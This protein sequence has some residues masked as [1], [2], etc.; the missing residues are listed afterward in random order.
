MKLIKIVCHRL[1]T[2]CGKSMIQKCSQN[3]SKFH[4]KD[5]RRLHVLYFSV[6]KAIQVFFIFDFWALNE[7]LFNCLCIG[8]I[9]CDVRFF[10]QENE[11]KQWPT[12]WGWIKLAPKYD[13]I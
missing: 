1:V 12:S 5:K 11:M 9:E 13:I 6:A 10:V 3:V 8:Q 2:N 4:A 7:C